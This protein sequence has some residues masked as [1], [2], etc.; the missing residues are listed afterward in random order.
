MQSNTVRIKIWKEGKNIIVRNDDFHINTYGEN[1][2]EA[3]EN[4][5]EAYLL[6]IEDKELF[7]GKNLYKRLLEFEK[8]IC[9]VKFSRKDLGF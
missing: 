7:K 5:H 4:F 9:R 6:T 1:L 3:L 2:D 8:N